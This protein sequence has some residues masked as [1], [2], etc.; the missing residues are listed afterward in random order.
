ML[1]S[2]QGDETLG[3]EISSSQF[4]FQNQRFSEVDEDLDAPVHPIT[5]E[6]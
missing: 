5:N 1:K 2:L 3:H 6:Q 4:N